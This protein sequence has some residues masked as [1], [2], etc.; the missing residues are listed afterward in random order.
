MVSGYVWL[1]RRVPSG[2]VCA[3]GIG[4][5]S[6]RFRADIVATDGFYVWLVDSDPVLHPVPEILEAHLGI[7]SVILSAPHISPVNLIP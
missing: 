3:E 7:S 4:A 1:C 2:A 5:A 6:W